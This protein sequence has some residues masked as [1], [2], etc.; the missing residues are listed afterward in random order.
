MLA[1]HIQRLVLFLSAFVIVQ[2]VG[3]SIAVAQ[4][5]PVTGDAP[6]SS[7]SKSLFGSM[8]AGTL[9]K[10]K[11]IAPIE[12]RVDPET[13]RLGPN[14]Q[15]LLAIP[16]LEGE[17]STGGYPLSVGMDNMLLL[18]RGFPMI[19]VNGMTLA[20]L[21]RTADSLFQIRG[22]KAFQGAT[23]SLLA[24]RTIFVTVSGDVLSPGPYIFTAA[25][26]VTTTLI[27]VNRIPE[28]LPDKQKGE[29]EREQLLNSQGQSG[30]Q[31]SSL[32]TTSDRPIRSVVIRHNDGTTSEADLA[33]YRAFGSDADNPTLREG[34]E[35]IVRRPLP[36][37]S[38]ISIAGAVNVGVTVAYR[39][40]D[41]AL[42]LLRL[43]SGLR[44]DAD[45][46]RAY[47]SRFSESGSARVPIDA[48]DTSSLASVNLQPGDQIVVPSRSVQR[49]TDRTGVV[50]IKGEVVAP[51][52]YPIVSGTTMLSDVIELA[53]G[54]TSD[55]SLAGAHI[56]RA[57]DPAQY[58]TKPLLS[59]RIAGMANSSLNLEDSTRF[60][61]DNE[62][63]QN[64]V[65]VD[66]IQLFGK[67]DKSKDVVLHNGDEIVIPKDPGGVYVYGR[68]N[69]PG[70]VSF[71][72]G[73]DN[74]QYVAAAGG[75][76]EA[77]NSDRVIVEKYGTGVWENVCCTQINSGDKIYVPG[78]RDT[79][80]RTSLETAS[81]IAFLASALVSIIV[82][83]L[84]FI[85][86]SNK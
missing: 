17:N 33:R 62:L 14:D 28:N 6:A 11:D 67:G 35:V 52:A 70:W 68:V 69:H 13:Y 64:R 2:I 22:G 51:S 16:A 47:I 78:D 75:Y 79:P 43:A 27:A 3:V 24:P 85:R 73:A 25:D 55:A 60:K 41:N 12:R 44:S 21:R 53:G 7:G 34:D 23:I 9:G 42:L 4:P 61:F 76:T 31:G 71:K 45:G 86:D 40:G 39:S 37:E 26:R 48:N 74:E 29:L 49:T 54:F 57:S 5:E 63:Q 77:A 59:D 8:Q 32:L 38:T 81:T 1:S 10:S 65:S 66:F 18:P 46:G 83:I 84:T 30:A 15:L 19:D 72:P 56:N 82:T 20:A 50:T 36:S 58:R 80:A